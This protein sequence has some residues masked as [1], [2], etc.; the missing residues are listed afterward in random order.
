M[1][2]ETTTRRGFLKGLGA[3]VALLTVAPPLIMAEVA[4]APET[5]HPLRHA[6]EF[7][8]R[9]GGKWKLIGGLQSFTSHQETV[10][11]LAFDSPYRGFQTIH[12]PMFDAELIVSQPAAF[13]ISHAV[14]DQDLVDVAVAFLDVELEMP[15]AWISNYEIE[16]VP[17]HMVARIS[18]S[19]GRAMT[20]RR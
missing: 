13:E 1:I 10:E 11:T 5:L 14:L 2:D 15:G 16:I 7:W 9:I 20:R 8:M 6:G 12:P 3:A 18:G 17:T 4:A 19:Y